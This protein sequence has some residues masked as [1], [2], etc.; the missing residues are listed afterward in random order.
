MN[1]NIILK[2]TAERT[3]LDLLGTTS[4]KVI[5]DKQFTTRGRT[6]QR[7]VHVKNAVQSLF[8]SFKIDVTTSQTYIS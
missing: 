5:H 2:Y 4:C 7:C 6:G 1:V 8:P 3:H